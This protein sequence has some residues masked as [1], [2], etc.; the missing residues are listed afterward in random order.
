[1][2]KPSN[3]RRRLKHIKRAMGY[4]KGFLAV[5]EAENHRRKGKK[6]F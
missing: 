2:E 3:W 4:V 6:I 5:E 1:M